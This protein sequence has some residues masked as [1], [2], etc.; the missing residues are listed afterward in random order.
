MP[1]GHKQCPQCYKLTGPRTKICSCGFKFLFKLKSLRPPKTQVID[2]TLLEH[3]D[4]IKV[5]QGSGPYWLDEDGEK[6]P[7]GYKGIFRVKRLDSQ[8]IHAYPV[9]SPD[10][11]HC[12]IYMGKKTRAETGTFMRPHRIRKLNKRIKK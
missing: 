9:K 6:M 12:Y 4:L 2:W 8:G 11:G 7:M 1:R 3:G 10:S 5:K